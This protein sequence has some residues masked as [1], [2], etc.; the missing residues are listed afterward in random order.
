LF[1]IPRVLSDLRCIAFD[2]GRFPTSRPFSA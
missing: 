1:I 2:S